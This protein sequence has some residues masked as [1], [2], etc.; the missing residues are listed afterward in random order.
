M[1]EFQ[2]T[3][4][5]GEFSPELWGRTDYQRW[6]AGSR[7]LFNFFVEPHGAASNRPGTLHVAGTKDNG[8][9][10]LVPFMFSDSD[11]LMLVFTHLRLRMYKLPENFGNGTT[12][13]NWSVLN[14]IGGDVD[15]VTP[16]DE[17]DDLTKLRVVQIG[18]VMRIMHPSY[19]PYELRRLADDNSRWL[20][21]EISFAVAPFPD[22]GG[23]PRVNHS[24]TK[25]VYDPD[26]GPIQLVERTVAP[27]ALLGDAQ[28]VPLEWRWKVTRIM[29][30]Q[31][32]REYETMP[33]TVRSSVARGYFPYTEDAN[34]AVGNVVTV[35]ELPGRIFSWQS[36]LIVPPETE[37]RPTN[38]P[39][40]TFWA[41]ATVASLTPA[42]KTLLEVV[43]PLPSKIALDLDWNVTI[44]WRT[45]WNNLLPDTNQRLDGDEIVATRIYRG[46]GGF[47]G[48]VGQVNA[49]D[50]DEFIDV[51]TRPNFE[52]PP[53]T[54]KNPLE[55]FSEAGVL[56]RTEKPSLAAIFQSRFLMAATAER[57][58]LVL[59]SAVE[60]YENF[61]KIDP[62]DDADAYSF[63]LA[64][65]KLEQLKALIPGR[66]LLGFTTSSLWE[67]TGSEGELVTPLS[68]AARP[69][70]S[71]GCSSLEPIIAQSTVLFMP[72]DGAAPLAM[73]YSTEGGGYQ[74]F[75]IAEASR[76]FFTNHTIVSWCYADVPHQLIYAAREDGVLLIGTFNRQQEMHAW[77]EQEI[78]GGGLVEWVATIP[79]GKENGVYLL[80][81]RDGVR[82]IE[83]FASR[84]LTDIRDA[85]FLDSAVRRGLDVN[86]E[87]AVLL[88]TYAEGG[89]VGTFLQV[90][91]GFGGA[92]IRIDDVIQIEN[93]DGVP[94]R[95]QMSENAGAGTFKAVVLDTDIP[96]SMLGD[97][98][99]YF[100]VCFTVIDVPHLAEGTEVIALIDGNVSDPLV[101]AQGQVEL[102]RHAAICAVG[103]AY[104]SDL[105]SLD[106]AEDKMK[107]KTT[108]RVLIETNGSRGGFVGSSPGP[109]DDIDVTQMEE[110]IDRDVNDGYA[111]IP[112]M[113]SVNEM[114]VADEYSARGGVAIRQSDPLPL[115]ILGFTRDVVLGGG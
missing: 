87:T 97:I 6:A 98:E 108:A 94:F 37:H 71:F 38:P 74:A 58:N 13:V 61:D 16:Y 79:E 70:A 3:F 62:P 51:G 104:N 18:N 59:G 103:L 27:L 23:E 9:G 57:M 80:V 25:T 101:V 113:R 91:W 39:D 75:E 52:D 14:P 2:T 115:T 46:I 109:N 36:V 102:G 68:I 19:S 44:T 49:G 99:H 8:T 24:I 31:Y 69:V 77:A 22:Y 64:S 84:Q 88:D 83:R 20:L 53:P 34:Y 111:A 17:S 82:T 93:P 72:R 32:G 106:S 54:G 76:H 86:N 66:V 67:V 40:A 35:P 45:S 107:K 114:N 78:A 92:G 30:D 105:I 60:D 29:K 85:V 89:A 7:K 4:G 112:L 33:F 11:V 63:E 95:L 28:H 100:S 81:N 56:L 48:W 47:F 73:A 96:A 10:I 110:V 1:K 65:L 5:G 15:I 12:A 26:T 43:S 21:E 41:T 90:G 55:F 50:G 42:E